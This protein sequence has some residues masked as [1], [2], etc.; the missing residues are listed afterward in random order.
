MTYVLVVG[1]TDNLTIM[2]PRGCWDQTS[3]RQLNEN[4]NILKGRYELDITDF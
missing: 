3:L 2:T 1:N 4:K